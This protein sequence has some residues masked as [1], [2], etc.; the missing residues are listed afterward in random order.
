MDLA[1]ISPDLVNLAK[2]GGTA[3]W[4]KFYEFLGRRLATNPPNIGVVKLGDS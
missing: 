2:Y 4:F 1:K 3:N